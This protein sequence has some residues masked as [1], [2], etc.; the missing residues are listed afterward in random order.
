MRKSSS[1][2]S[3]YKFSFLIAVILHLVLL[4]LFFIAIKSTSK[5]SIVQSNQNIIKAIA[6]SQ[7]T[8]HNVTS[9]P[10]SPPVKAVS[11]AKNNSPTEKK[12][13]QPPPISKK[14]E[15]KK[16]MVQEK[17][18]EETHEKLLANQQLLKE[19]QAKE[20]AKKEALAEKE[21]AEKL[22]QE[23]AH[24][25]QE[26]IKKQQLLAK[27]KA[28]E[29]IKKKAQKLAE[30]ALAQQI[31]EENAAK[32]KEEKKNQ[33]QELKKLAEEQL[34]TALANHEAKE[35]TTT[36]QK[37]LQATKELLEQEVDASDKS[38]VQP[39]T[40]VNQGEID[41]YKA[42][43]LQAIS[44]QWIVPEAVKKGLETKLA[45]RIA[46]GGA[47]LSVKI[48][49]TSGDA[50]LDRSAQTAVLKASPLPVPK[51]LTTFESFRTINLT[52]RPEGIVATG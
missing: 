29:E 43:I 10:V 2:N 17:P 33:Q 13:E 51:D 12:L 25:Q 24:Q 19:Q 42:L 39:P 35:Q 38:E 31:T 34:Q 20:Q 26:E 52:A 4:S 16:L 6:V 3:D 40:N 37:Q 21:A 36:H 22:A 5:V 14:P 30:S 44:Q 32:Q 46:P 23:Q 47:V 8:L 9:H 49:Q 27:K 41:K 15:P 7:N 18:K 50:I 48:I 1:N 45:V 11:I 28:Q